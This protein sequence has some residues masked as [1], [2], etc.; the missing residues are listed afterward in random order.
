MKNMT[1][2]NLTI[3]LSNGQTLQAENM[4]LTLPTG[5]T[6]LMG[7]RTLMIEPKCPGAAIRDA[8]EAFQKLA[9]ATARVTLKPVDSSSEQILIKAFRDEVREILI[10]AE[11]QKPPIWA[12]KWKGQRS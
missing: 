9:T 10:E 3:T 7:S 6:L 12:K 2:E 5:E 1:I 11:K 4:T 8:E